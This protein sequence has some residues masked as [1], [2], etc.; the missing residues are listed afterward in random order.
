MVSAGADHD[1]DDDRFFSMCASPEELRKDVASTGTGNHKHRSIIG[2]IND[3]AHTTMEDEQEIAKFASA[4]AKY[5]GPF[6]FMWVVVMAADG[7][8][9]LA[10]RKRYSRD[11][12]RELPT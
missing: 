8:Y 2:A 5:A 9:L 10:A 3:I 12:H 6:I 4:L 1:H 11:N 7:S